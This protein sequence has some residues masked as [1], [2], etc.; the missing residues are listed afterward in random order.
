[1]QGNSK[2]G[3]LVGIFLDRMEPLKRESHGGLVIS[4]S[5]MLPPLPLQKPKQLQP[6]AQPLVKDYNYYKKV[7]SDHE[8]GATMTVD[9]PK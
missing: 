4:P 2:N 8:D 9:K 3:R 5:T 1:M 7:F 6:A